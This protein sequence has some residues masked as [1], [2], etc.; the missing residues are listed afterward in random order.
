[1]LTAFKLFT[2]KYKNKKNKNTIQQQTLE[3]EYED[4]KIRRSYHQFFQDKFKFIYVFGT[5]SD[6]LT[7]NSIIVR[8]QQRIF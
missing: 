2:V 1:M 8:P 5:K 4:P 3:H 7:Q 6:C